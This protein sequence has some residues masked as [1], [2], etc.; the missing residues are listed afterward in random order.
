MAI[1]CR[2]K[3]HGIEKG[4]SCH[5]YTELY[6]KEKIA[7][8]KCSILFLRQEITFV[9]LQYLCNF[10]DIDYLLLHTIQFEKVESVH[11][12]VSLYSYSFIGDSLEILKD[13][14]LGQTPNLRYKIK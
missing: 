7:F 10:K 5:K 3:K 1:K 2:W 8:F 9:W 6:R 13:G 12:K 11:W 4:G 14:V